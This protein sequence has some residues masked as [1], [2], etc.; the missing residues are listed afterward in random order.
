MLMHSFFVQVI[1]NPSNLKETGVV[2][3]SKWRS[4]TTSKNTVICARIIYSVSLT[5]SRKIVTFELWNTESSYWSRVS[6]SWSA[7]GS[8]LPCTLTISRASAMHCCLIS[9]RKVKCLVWPNAIQL[10]PPFQRLGCMEGQSSFKTS[11]LT[12]RPTKEISGQL[13]LVRTY[14]V[15]LAQSFT[16][17]AWMEELCD[18]FCSGLRTTFQAQLRVN[19]PRQHEGYE[20]GIDR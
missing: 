16:F 5:V 13:H 12:I 7:Q 18:L 1:V 3:K 20:I 14:V 15:T 8:F 2:I 4:G 17:W 9:K 11:K 19:Y 6:I 10:D